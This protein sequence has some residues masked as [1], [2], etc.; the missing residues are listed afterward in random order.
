MADGTCKSNAESGN[1][2]RR[3]DGDGDNEG[4]SGWRKGEDEVIGG[5]VAMGRTEGSD[6]GGGGRGAVDGNREA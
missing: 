2:S 3:S 5:V 1:G 6:G 4:S